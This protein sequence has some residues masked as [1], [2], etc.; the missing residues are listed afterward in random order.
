MLV[1][2]TLLVRGHWI[3]KPAVERGV[4]ACRGFKLRSLLP[5][6]EHSEGLISERSSSMPKGFSVPIVSVSII[7]LPM[8]VATSPVVLFSGKVCGRVEVTVSVSVSER[9]SGCCSR[10]TF[11]WSLSRVC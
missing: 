6:V 1:K 10:G 9:L 7:A 3:D 4:S 2:G 5:N 8:S 11:C